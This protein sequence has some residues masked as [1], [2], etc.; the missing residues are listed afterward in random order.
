[1]TSGQGASNNFWSLAE[2]DKVYWDNY[3]AARPKYDASTFYETIYAYHDTHSGVYDVAHDV[4]AGPGQVAK[5]IASKFKSVVASDNNEPHL[6]AA[7]H[8][9]GSIPNVEFLL[10]LGE[11]V[12]DNVPAS[13]SDMVI[14]AEAIP[15]MDRDKAI[16]GFAQMLKPDGTL[17]IWF[18]GRPFFADGNRDACQ[19][20]YSKLINTTVASMLRHSTP[21]FKAGWKHGT[22]TIAGQLDA[23]AFPQ[24]TWK[25]VQR[26]K[27]NMH[28]PMEFNDQEAMPDL[29]IETSSNVDYENEKIVEIKDET[30]WAEPWDVTEV[31]NFIEAILPMNQSLLDEDEVQTALKELEKAMGGPGVKRAV[32]WPVVLLLAAKR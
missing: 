2:Y 28:V 13:S 7:K 6:V 27:W 29:P 23:V 4:G 12:A 18:Y 26:L 19:A 10:C 11:D 21:G 5:V 32:S 1:M 17:A 3:L 22:E 30:F 8:H 9:H 25:D 20:A 31:R 24:E 14:C 16:S 15:L